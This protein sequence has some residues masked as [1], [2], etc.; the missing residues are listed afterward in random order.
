MIIREVQPQYDRFREEKA[1]GKQKVV[2]TE[3]VPKAANHYARLAL[4]KCFKCNQPCHRSS[5]CLLRKT[6]H[7]AER[8]EDD[9]NE[10]CYEPMG[11]TK[12]D[13]EEDDHGHN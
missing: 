10:V 11:R 6:V 5:D 1:A 3:E 4:V 9:D 12:E 7:L 8:E 2:E 13:Y